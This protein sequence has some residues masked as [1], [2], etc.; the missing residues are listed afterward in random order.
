[1]KEIVLNGKAIITGSGSLSYLKNIEFTRAF[2]VTGGQS[3]S[4]S[5]VIDR[6]KKYLAKD[7]KEITI[8]SGIKKN[9]NYKEVLDGLKVMREKSPDLVI[10]VGGGSAMDAAKAMLL[11]YE[12]PQLNFENILTAE[13]PKERKKARLMCIPSTSG[14]ASEMTPVAVITNVE[15]GIKV[16]IKAPCLRPDIAILDAD[17]TMTMP[18]QIAAETGMDALTHAIEAYTNYNLDDFN[19]AICGS[20]IKGIMKWLPISCE[21]ATLESRDKMHNYQCMAGIGFANV[22][23]GM[24][25]G[26]AHSYGAIYDL[27][28]G[29]AN[30]IILPFVLDYNKRDSLVARKLKDISYYCESKDIVED[31]KKLKKKIGIPHSFKELGISEE[32]F[33]NDFKLILNHSMLGATKVNPVL[34]TLE[35]MEKMIKTVY[36]S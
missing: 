35:S 13:I 33:K 22:G 32:D 30:A 14:T 21:E 15:E 3:M 34:M 19:E 27:P 20:A 4:N 24:V 25:H 7:D 8:Y 11:F 17:I 6:I 28:H 12:F 26:I 16:P 5:G 36:L 2:I 9:P 29:V 23:L 10:A 31:I 18:A 1:M